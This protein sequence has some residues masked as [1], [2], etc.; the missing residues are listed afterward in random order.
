[1]FLKPSV[2]VNPVVD[3]APPELDERHPQFSEE[4]DSDSEVRRSLFR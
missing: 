3:G 4:R 2:E 1:M